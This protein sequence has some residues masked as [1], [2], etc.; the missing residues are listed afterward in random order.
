LSEAEVS[1]AWPLCRLPRVSLERQAPQTA[2][3][4]KKA[5][6]VPKALWRSFTRGKIILSIS[7]F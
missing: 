7:V 5:E 1:A 3:L 6:L 2:A 4:Q